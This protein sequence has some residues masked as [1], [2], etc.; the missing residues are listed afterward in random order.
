MAQRIKR[1]A[2]CI[3]MH[4]VLGQMRNFTTLVTIRFKITLIKTRDLC[5]NIPY[6]DAENLKKQGKCEKRQF[7]VI[8]TKSYLCILNMFIIETQVKRITKK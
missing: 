6:H 7:K 4:Q 3:D 5:K 1:L 2:M 8:E